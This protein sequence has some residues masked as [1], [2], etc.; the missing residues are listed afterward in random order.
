M[1]ETMETI[2][3]CRADEVGRASALCVRLPRGLLVALARL[4]DGSIVA[5]ENV[6]PHKAAPLGEGRIRA[7]VV[8]CPWHGFRFD[9]RTGKTVGLDSI[10]KLRLF[11]VSVRDGDV[12]VT[13]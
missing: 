10:M 13:P 2:R 4:E 6:C 1:T 9:L 3:A 12:Y 8:T 7:G 5:F 11:A